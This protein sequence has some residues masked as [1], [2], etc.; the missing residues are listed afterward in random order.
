MKKIL[1]AFVYI[2]A[3]LFIL[4]TV[5]KLTTYNVHFVHACRTDDSITNC[6]T[7]KATIV[8]D[9][10]DGRYITSMYDLTTG[11]TITFNPISHEDSYEQGCWLGTKR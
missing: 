5:I 7:Y 6:G 4:Q 9:P 1:S 11:T 8:F 2:S 3:T 10:M